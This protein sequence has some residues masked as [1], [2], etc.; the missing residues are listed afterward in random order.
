M[1]NKVA[2][3]TDGISSLTPAMGQEYGIHVMPIYVMFG[4][5]SYLD[6]VDLDS[7]K[8]YSL[9]NGNKQLPTT[10][11]PT[12]ADFVRAYTELSQKAEAIVSIHA[13]KKV[14]ATVDCA[15]TACKELPDVPIYVIDTRT[16][17]MAEGQIA[18]AAA[19][20]A[21]DGQD[22]EQIVQ[23]VEELSPKTNVIFTVETL[24]YLRRGGRIGA[25]SALLG[26][27]LQIKPVLHI[28]DGQVA[29]LE[30]PRTKK[31]AIERVLDLMAERVGDKPVN[32]AVL[33]CHALDE[34]QR[35]AE[36]VTT[37]FDCQEL[38]ITEAGP[39]I[40]THA[41]PGTLG[42]TFYTN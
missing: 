33:H 8:F 12:V 21:A 9:L 17:A 36:R 5:T 26:S 24:E 22:A 18:I 28:E 39:V 30:K 15:Q 37:R 19:R 29:P 23:L 10:S 20:A 3:V 16:L 6:G 42:V 13:S 4:T 7:E 2:I 11:Q 35:L 40:G 31:R 1:S 41:G 25:A 14:S 32:A 38:L 34:A 27:A